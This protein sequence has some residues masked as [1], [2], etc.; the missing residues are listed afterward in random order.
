MWNAYNPSSESPGLRA[1]AATQ[2]ACDAYTTEIN[3]YGRAELRRWAVEQALC[4]P[5]HW[6]V[7]EVI[8]DAELLVAYVVGKKNAA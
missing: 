1:V 3:D 8:R 6:R 7:D 2:A 5:G 4:R